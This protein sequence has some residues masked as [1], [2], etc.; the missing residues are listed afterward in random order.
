MDAAVR[1]RAAEAV[2]PVARRAQDLHD[3]VAR[4]EAAAEWSANELR[5]IAPQIAAIEWRLG[6]LDDH[7]RSSAVAASPAGASDRVLL[8]LIRAEHGRVR[9]RLSAIASYEE[10]LR[11]LET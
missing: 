2:D 7:L 9:A 4:V 3:W 11:R 5:R 8:D 6:D 1:W 10:R